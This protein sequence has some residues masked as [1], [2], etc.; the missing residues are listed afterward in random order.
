[1]KYRI[2]K[3]ICALII[4]SLISVNIVFSISN[5]KADSD[6]TSETIKY[7]GYWKE[8]SKKYENKEDSLNALHQLTRLP[9]INND[10]P[11]ITVLVHGYDGDA[12]HWSNNSDWK[13]AYDSN[14]LIE[15]LRNSASGANVYLARFTSTSMVDILM[16]RC[17]EVDNQYVFTN[18]DKIDDVSKTQSSFLNLVL[19]IHTI[20][21]FMQNF[22]R[23]LIWY[24]MIF[25][26]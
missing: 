10:E 1:M 13:F 23:L 17:D 21:M 5:I 2:F 25:C 15:E 19:Q 3:Y 16:Q 20:E 14:S 8:V 4:I 6:S 22:M 7:E 24:H 26:I 9:S 12:S 11:S 18:L